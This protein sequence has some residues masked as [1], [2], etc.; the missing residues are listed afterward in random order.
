MFGSAN[1]W[2]GVISWLTCQ[3]VVPTSSLLHNHL[4]LLYPSD[5]YK[6]V[7][8]YLCLLVS[9]QIQAS[10]LSRG[11]RLVGWYHSHPASEPRPSEN[12]VICQQKYQ[13]TMMSGENGIPCIAL[14]TS[15]TG[16]EGGEGDHSL[17]SPD[18]K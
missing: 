2:G 18:H 17:H 5:H 4:V 3:L 10:M 11:L 16:D 12:D 14:I 6:L 13:E 9:P 15:K 8:K 1:I 7:A